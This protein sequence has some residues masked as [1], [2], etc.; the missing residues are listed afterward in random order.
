MLRLTLLVMQKIMRNNHKLTT[1]QLALVL[2]IMTVGSKVLGFVRELLLANYYG[3]SFIT[4]AYTMSMSIP[5][6]L[7]AGIVG[8]A[9]TAYMPVYSKKFESEGKESGDLFT[10]QIINLL[11]CV[12]GVVMVLGWIFT[13]PLVHLF[14]PG[15]TGET[16][17]LTAY[18]LRIAFVMVFF[19]V[20]SNILTSFLQYN[21]VFVSQSLVTYLQNICIVAA[22]IV[23][24]ASSPTFL[25]I[26]S[27]PLSNK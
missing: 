11:L 24:A 2:A 20:V 14:A 13:E 19:S 18:Y 27:I 22:I 17:A 25:R 4:D 16:F 5:N 7:L 26:L 23:S 6:N 12:V 9:A 21:K 3:A 10:S 8:A 15:F 1:T